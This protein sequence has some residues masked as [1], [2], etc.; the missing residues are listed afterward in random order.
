M[1]HSSS[2]TWGYM[3]FRAASQG[4][5][6]R[7][8]STRKIRINICWG[9][10]HTMLPTIRRFKLADFPANERT[11]SAYLIGQKDVVNDE[12]KLCEVFE[13]AVVHLSLSFQTIKIQRASTAIGLCRTKAQPSGIDACM[14]EEIGPF[15]LPKT[16][17]RS[18]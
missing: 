9:R 15:P 17:F 3:N 1:Y 13:R 18:G 4:V 6:H 10:G 8:I 12:K 7:F 11:F 14:K 16:P 5:P 2:D